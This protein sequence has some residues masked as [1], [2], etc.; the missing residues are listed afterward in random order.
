MDVAAARESVHDGVQ[1][2]WRCSISA[3]AA[4][5]HSDTSR[6][7]ELVARTKATILALDEIVESEQAVTNEVEPQLW[8]MDQPAFRELVSSLQ[9]KISSKD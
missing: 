2:E 4:G 5:V 6:D 1:I 7:R 8:S 9:Q 3:S